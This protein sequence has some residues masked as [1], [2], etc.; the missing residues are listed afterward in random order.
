MGYEF[1]DSGGTRNRRRLLGTAVA[2]TAIALIA[3]SYWT[4]QQVE[5]A[6]KQLAMGWRPIISQA[7]RGNSQTESFQIDTGQWRIKWTATPE[8]G[9][10]SP[11]DTLRIAVHSAVSGRMM[12]V[13]VDHQGAGSG[14]AY[15][16][17]E[18]RPF[19]VSI[20]SSGL[21]WTVQIEEGSLGERE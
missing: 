18:P 17:E 1:L 16:A 20:E 9:P 14:V 6:P 2:M 4:R 19:F 3:G 8:E 12:S 15:V 11:G 13:A 10:V 7:G 5:R 21:E